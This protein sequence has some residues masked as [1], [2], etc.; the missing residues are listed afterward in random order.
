MFTHAASI[1]TSA[2]PDRV[3][4]LWSDV[5]RWKDWNTGIESIQLDGPFAEGSHFTMRPPGQ[6]PIVSRLVDV[7]PHR[8]F[9]DETVLGDTRV[10]VVHELQ[11]R[12]GGMTRIVYSTTITG[13]DAE[14]IGGMVTSDF[15]DVLA[16]LK[17]LAEQA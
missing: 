15:D 4:S 12:P 8:R 2:P 14:E 17:R 9:S 11:P 6:D 10:V 16:A 3:W 1:E 7:M 13:P 5:D